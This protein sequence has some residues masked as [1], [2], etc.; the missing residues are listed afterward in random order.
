MANPEREHHSISHELNGFHLHVDKIESMSL[1]NRL[2]EQSNHLQDSMVKLSNR[3][4]YKKSSILLSISS[5]IMNYA[6]Y[7]G[8]Y[9]PFGTIFTNQKLG[10]CIFLNST[11]WK[12]CNFNFMCIVSW[13]CKFNNMR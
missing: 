9:I 12:L 11:L 2:L 4:F 10:W 1:P 7:L 8:F 3:I 13:R 5:T 6:N